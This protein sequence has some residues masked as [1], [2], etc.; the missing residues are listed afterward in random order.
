MART[1]TGYS[2][3][4][5]TGSSVLDYADLGRRAGATIGWAGADDQGRGR[6]KLDTGVTVLGVRVQTS[7]TGRP[8]LRGTAVYLGSAY[9]IPGEVD[10]LEP[11]QLFGAATGG[12]AVEAIADACTAAFSARLDA[13]GVPHR[14]VH[15]D[16]GAHT[17]GLFEAEMRDSWN[18]VIGPALGS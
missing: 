5:L 4:E 15:R 7:V 12:A 11:Y 9:G 17:W 2:A 16:R 13:V 18:T 1:D 8:E 14:F 6:V 3:R 10:A